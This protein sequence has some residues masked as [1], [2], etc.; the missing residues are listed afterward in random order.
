MK[1]ALL[2]TKNRILKL[3]YLTTFT[4]IVLPTNYCKAAEPLTMENVTKNI[5]EVCR[6]PADSNKY[7]DIKIESSGDTKV[8]LK[9]A[10]INISGQA[11]FSKGEWQG[12]QRVLKEQQAQDN[13]SYR[14]CAKSLTPLFLNK[15]F[16]EKNPPSIDIPKNTNTNGQEKEKI[17]FLSIGKPFHGIVKQRKRNH[18]IFLTIDKKDNLGF[19]GKIEY[20]NL[21]AT[22][23]IVGNIYGKKVSFN[24]KELIS[25]EYTNAYIGIAYDLE[26][27][28]EKNQLIGTWSFNTDHGD[29]TINLY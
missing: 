19:T 17:N 10:D 18:S 11:E 20:I 5:I 12:V 9:L 28:P 23:T 8:K 2:V 14:D 7:W 27:S 13:A 21:K 16:P 3:L 24:E 29:V 1:L 15:F 26:F 22:K 4:F 25:K 6:A